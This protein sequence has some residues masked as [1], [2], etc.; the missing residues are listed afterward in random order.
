LEQ[1]DREPIGVHHGRKIT[2]P[3]TCRLA[4]A[5]SAAAVSASG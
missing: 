4:I 5:S 2:L 1:H 3:I